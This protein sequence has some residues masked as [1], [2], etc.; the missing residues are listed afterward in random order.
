MNHRVIL[1][2]N[3]AV[4]VVNFFVSL[5]ATEAQ[6][7]VLRTTARVAFSQPLVPPTPRP[8]PAPLPPASIHHDP[9]PTARLVKFLARSEEL[10][11]LTAAQVDALFGAH[12]YCR[13]ELEEGGSKL[14]GAAYGGART[15]R[16]LG[17]LRARV[18]RNVEDTFRAADVSDRELLAR[19]VRVVL[20]SAG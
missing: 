15:R 9:S 7:Q 8:A 1:L 14:R 13:A 12:D 17:D 19:L 10:N 20:A 18:R 6:T 16:L 5:G 11:R 4:L 2:L 3:L